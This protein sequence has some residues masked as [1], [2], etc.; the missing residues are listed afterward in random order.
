MNM[1][2]PEYRQ[3]KSMERIN[4][5]FGSS[6]GAAPRPQ[7]RLS[8]ENHKPGIPPS[9]PNLSPSTPYG[10]HSASHRMRSPNMSPGS[11][12]SRSLSQPPFF[13]LD[14]L[15]PLS[16]SPYREPS[17]SSLSDP[18]STDVSMEESAVNSHAPAPSVPANS[19]GY[20]FQVAP[21]LP[22]RKGHRRSSS[23]TPL[24]ISSFI[25]SSPQFV[26][27]GTWRELDN[28][29]SRGE[30]SVSQKPIQLVKRESTKVGDHDVYN[31]ELMHESKQDMMDD[32]LSSYMNFDNFDN[33]HFSG[34]EDKDL[35][36][37]TSGSKT[38]E[39]SDN[40]VESHVN[41]KTTSMQGMTSSCAEEKREGIK[42]SSNGDIAPAGR[43][44]R[45]FSLDS[46][47]GNLHI[48]DELPKLPPLGN[49]VD[50]HS[51]SNS[52]DG[53]TSEV[54]MEFGNG[55]FN[56]VELKKIMENDKL[57]EIASS[58][59]KRA[60]RILANRQS[61]ARS[62]ERKMRY[63]GELEHK[64]QTLQTETTTLSTQFTKLQRD[65]SELKSENNELKF[66]VQAMDQQSQL[67]DALNE[68]LTAEVQRLR[69][70]VAELGGD[71]LLSGCMARQLAINQQRFQLQ[72]QQSGHSNVKPPSSA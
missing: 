20:A 70:T 46:S 37:R 58:D 2:S 63:I 42:R 72:N 17:V 24:G 44:R 22:P 61:A 15:P 19:R 18:I 6:S 59:P 7:N 50:Q 35:D 40:E 4:S 68:T 3:S 10:S 51:P 60:K 64:V 23:D 48:E 31:A 57:A 38:V 41:G 47:I 45:S 32:L 12:H 9:H 43:H 65:H 13:S 26:P 29:G 16:P 69:R 54:S 8:A 62:K 5:A 34:M 53:K 11:S 33:L 36:S 52:I 30:S 67:K 21:S 25:Q 14:S 71:S 66:R 56:S 39:S 27:A 28:L 49:R 1:S 55:E